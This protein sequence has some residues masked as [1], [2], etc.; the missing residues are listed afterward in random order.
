MF[1]QKK[2][3][4]RTPNDPK[5]SIAHQSLRYKQT[6]V[7]AT[8]NCSFFF[9]KRIQ[10]DQIRKMKTHQ[11]DLLALQE[12]KVNYSSEEIKQLPVLI[13]IRVPF[14]LEFANL[15]QSS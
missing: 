3:Q 9:Q 8:L 4:K 11:I 6:I 10:R 13:N 12:T 2:I 1:G 7:I 5:P 14:Q 15:E